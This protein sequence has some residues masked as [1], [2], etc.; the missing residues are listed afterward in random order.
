MIIGLR[1][2]F[3]KDSLSELQVQELVKQYLNFE[4][5]S[6]TLDLKTYQWNKRK[7]ER[8]LDVY[9]RELFLSI[10]D[11]KGNAIS[12]G[13]TGTINPHLSIAIEQS[14]EIFFPSDGGVL[15]IAKESDGFVSAYIYDEEYKYVQSEKFDN[16]LKWRQFSTGIL[17]SIKNTPSDMGTTSKEYDIRF[18]PGRLDLIQ[19]TWLM[20]TWK[21]WF[22]NFF[23]K[24]VPKEKILSFPDASQISEINENL[25]MVQLFNKIEESHLPE[26]MRR[27]WKWRDWLD[28]DELIKRYR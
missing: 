22:G 19:Y 4:P 15:K 28:Y 21:M 13:M 2:S 6:F 1:L 18:N 25:I 14:T 11:L 10:S 12:I 8:I 26:N 16:N 5:D 20:A 7:F 3:E 27:Q 24:I 17:E 9:H 23:F